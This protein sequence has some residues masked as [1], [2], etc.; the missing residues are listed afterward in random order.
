[1]GTDVV[2]AAVGA[3][4]NVTAAKMSKPLQPAGIDPPDRYNV[5]DC[6]VGEAATGG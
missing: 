1:M 6:A 2:V 4:S 3:A 5:D